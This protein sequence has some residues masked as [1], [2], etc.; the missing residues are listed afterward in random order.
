MKA[1]QFRIRTRLTVREFRKDIGLRRSQV[2]AP[3]GLF[4]SAPR[5]AL[6]LAQ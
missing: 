3:K 5:R 4:R 2:A 1:S 6:N